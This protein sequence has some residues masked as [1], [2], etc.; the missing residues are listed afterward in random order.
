ME[1]RLFFPSLGIFCETDIDF[2][3]PNLDPPLFCRTSSGVSCLRRDSTEDDTGFLPLRTGGTGGGLGLALV[4]LLNDFEGLRPDLM[5]D[6][7][8]LE[9]RPRPRVPLGLA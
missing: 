1:N 2:D 8:C 5:L 3:R 6:P 9:L 7:D 4:P